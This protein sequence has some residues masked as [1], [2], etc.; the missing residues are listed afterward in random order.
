MHDH[1]PDLGC[2]S[3]QKAMLFSSL[4]SVSNSFSA[5]KTTA[6]GENKIYK[7]CIIFIVTVVAVGT[8]VG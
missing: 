7:N 3:L 2:R 8:C 6:R 4:P 5:I 1:V